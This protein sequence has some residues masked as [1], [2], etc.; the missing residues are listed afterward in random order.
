M[1][2]KIGLFFHLLIQ[3]QCVISGQKGLGGE[4]YKMW[5]GKFRN[6]P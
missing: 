3:A 2:N 1:F 4:K 6:A 5:S